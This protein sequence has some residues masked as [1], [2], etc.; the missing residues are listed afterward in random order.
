VYASISLSSAQ[1]KVETEHGVADTSSIAAA[2]GACAAAAS[3]SVGAAAAATAPEPSELKVEVA[4]HRERTCGLA[5]SWIQLRKQCMTNT[6][7]RALVAVPTYKILS[8]WLPTLDASLRAQALQGLADMHAEG[9]ANEK[10]TTLLK[11]I[12][13][14]LQLTCADTLPEGML[15]DIVSTITELANDYEELHLNLFRCVNTLRNVL[16]SRTALNKE[17]FAHLEPRKKR[18]KSRR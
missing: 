18:R 12:A 10:F 14:V 2:A 6:P 9:I 7:E 17:K 4:G 16:P 15:S 13:I 5:S 8:A 3:P 11:H 1:P